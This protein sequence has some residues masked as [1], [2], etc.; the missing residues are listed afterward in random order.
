MMLVPRLRGALVDRSRRIRLVFAA[1]LVVAM[2]TG[3]SPDGPTFVSAANTYSA[4]TVTS[5]LDRDDVVGAEG[6]PTDEARDKQQDALVALR[7]QGAEGSKAA[8]LI[9]ETFANSSPGVPFY[10]ERATFDGT[11]AL[12]VAEVIGPKGGTLKDKRVWVIDD[13]GQI[14]FSA[15]R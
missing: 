5:V 6:S 3:C 9:T 1:I 15:T 7:R 4:E 2:M 12:I 14:L 10:V 11:E 13:S 8:D